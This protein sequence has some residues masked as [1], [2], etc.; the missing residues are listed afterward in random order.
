MGERVVLS[1]LH[2]DAIDL[3]N[4]CSDLK[5]VC[6]TLYSADYRLPRE[7]KE[8]KIFMSF[9]PMLCRRNERS[10]SDIVKRMRIGNPEGK[11][12]VEEK[13]D[14]ERIQLHKRGSEFR[15]FSRKDKDYTCVDA[16]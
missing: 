10:V 9:R 8:V 2:E 5:R 7:G 4:V 3:F 6:Y 14:G 16:Q 11:F 12:I 13:L 15:Y 1:S